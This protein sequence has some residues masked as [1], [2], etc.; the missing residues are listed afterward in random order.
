MGRSALRPIVGSTVWLFSNSPPTAYPVAAI[1]VGVSTPQGSGG[2]GGVFD[3]V[4][5]LP[6]G[7]TAPSLGVPFY[8]GTRPAPGAVNW[9]TPVRV[10]MPASPTSWPS[11]QALGEG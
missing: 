11:G 2:V 7:N 8:Y 6:T 5:L 3:L 10:N 1:V 9:C 4:A